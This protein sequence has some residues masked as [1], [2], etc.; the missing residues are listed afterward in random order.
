VL[1]ELEDGGTLRYHRFEGSDGADVWLEQPAPSGR[2]PPPGAAMTT[3]E[4]IAALTD[5]V[6]ERRRAGRGLKFRL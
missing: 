2:E 1:I 6:K 4:L 5:S 3:A